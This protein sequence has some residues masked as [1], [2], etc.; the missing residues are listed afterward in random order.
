[1]PS[2][3]VLL[4]HTLPSGSTHYDWMFEH[5]D[6]A[7][8]P[9]I[10]FR[11]SDRPDLAARGHRIRSERLGDHRRAYLDYEGPLSANRGSVKRL[12]HGLLL[13]L[14]ET[15]TSLRLTLR[16]DQA[17]VARWL[18]TP[19]SSDPHAEPP[20]DPHTDPVWDWSRDS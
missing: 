8:G 14:A 4:E 2:R 18:A 1:M 6:V 9:L 5:P 10:S 13:S 7:G 19:V 11:L 16:W 12:A 15:P 3:M 17:P 20:P